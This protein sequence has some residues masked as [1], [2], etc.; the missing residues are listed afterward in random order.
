MADSCIRIVPSPDLA[1]M[2]RAIERAEAALVA[3]GMDADPGVQ[4]CV[5]DI[6]NYSYSV[7]CFEAHL[8]GNEVVYSLIDDRLLEMFA[9]FQAY[10]NIAFARNRARHEGRL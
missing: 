4:A 7:A 2:Y 6:C 3:A 10:A 1:V 8:V 5:A 9:R